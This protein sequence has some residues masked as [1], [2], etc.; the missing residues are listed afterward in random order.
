MKVS[1]MYFDLFI[2]KRRADADCHLLLTSATPLC[3][4]PL[5]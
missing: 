4:P 1:V 5:L 3:N 2:Q